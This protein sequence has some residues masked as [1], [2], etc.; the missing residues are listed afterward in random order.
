MHSNV[1]LCRDEGATLHFSLFQAIG[2]IDSELRTVGVFS[3]DAVKEQSS[4]S[5]SLGAA[6]AADDKLE[7]GEG[8][9]S[10]SAPKRY[11]RGVVFYL[12]EKRVVGVLLWNLFN[13]LHVARQVRVYYA[14]FVSP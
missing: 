8:A 3:A 12:R 11:D 6:D 5:R 1:R 7:S 4:E 14:S 9:K 10:E 13:R 2:I